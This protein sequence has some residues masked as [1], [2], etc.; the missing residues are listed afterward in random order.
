MKKIKDKDRS[1]YKRRDITKRVLSLFAAAVISAGPV[2]TFVGCSGIKDLLNPTNAKITTVDFSNLPGDP[3]VDIDNEEDPAL[4][5][6]ELMVINTVGEKDAYGDRV[7]WIE[8]F[9]QSTETVMLSDYEISLN[10]EL[11]VSLPQMT[12]TPGEY[13]V[14]YANGKSGG[15]DIS[16]TLPVKGLL[17]LRHN[18]FAT[19]KVSYLNPNANCSYLPQTGTETSQPTPGY[20]AVKEKDSIVISE[21]MSTNDLYPVD[22]KL[23]DWV[24]IFN[25]GENAVDLSKYYASNVPSD[26]YRC[27][28]PSVTLTP[29]EYL[30]LSCGGDLNFN[31]SKSGDKV[32]ITR[33]D[34]VIAS[35][36]TFDAMEKNTAWTYDRGIITKPSPGY[37]NTDDGCLAAISSHV[38]LIITEVISSNSKYNA[39]DGE[40]HD[41]VELKNATDSPIKLSD[42]CLSDKSSNLSRYILPDVTLAAGEYY[43]VACDGKKY[44]PFKISSKGEKLYV[45]KIDGTVI[46]ALEIPAVPANRS[47]GRSSDGTLVYFADPTFGKANGVGYTTIVSA[48]KASLQSGFYSGV[49]NVTLS[50]EGT[51]YYTT[52]GSKPT[53][54]SKVYDGKPIAVSGVMSIRVVAYDGDR[55][56]SDVTTFNYFIDIPDYSNPV[57]KISMAQADFDGTNGIYTKYNNTD[58]EKEA[59]FAYYVGG[60]EQFSVNCGIKIFGAS[61]RMYA[62]KSFQLKFRTKY[63]LSKLDYKFFDD[64]DI[65]EFNNIVMR[66]GSQ[67]IM[68][69]RTMLTDE[70]ITSIAS[71]SGNMKNVLVQ[72]Y[73]PINLYINDRYMGVYFFR[74]KIDEDF[75]ANHWGVDPD[76]VTIINW[77]NSVKYGTSDQGWHDLWDFVANKK[78]DLTKDENYQKVISQINVES[79]MDVY[80]MRIWGGDR[81]S[82]NIRA[83][84]SPDYDNGRW[85]FL[86]FDC[87]LCLD[88][89]STKDELDYIMNN[90]SIARLHTLFRSLMK[91]ENFKKEFLTRLGYHLK[92]TFTPEKTQGRFD[93]LVAEVDPDMKYNVECWKDTYHKTYSD[94][95]AN[96]NALR[97]SIGETRISLFVRDAVK[98]FSLTEDDVRTYFGE[99]FVAYMN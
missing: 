55:I 10:D 61:S 50:G 32:F 89:G 75:V 35:S 27:Q 1:K 12:L 91:N 57:V 26:L 88:V 13:V 65:T 43:V 48:P 81:D 31:L 25:A 79:F 19:A 33:S 28:L 83:A 22:G 20:A 52:D 95:K 70:L 46:D 41:L 86:L 17:I 97:K 42:Y 92:N 82:G 6:T 64:L 80:I 14:L 72:A 8:I 67:S 37:P 59:G 3:T 29:G 93:A 24:E 21:L 49:Q 11:P 7:G 84:K 62:K 98:T 69:Y 58:L 15:R 44:A 36:C 34:G 63:G 87:D 68:K 60:V 56:P 99:E 77:V 45:S 76:S 85:N 51:L 23:C 30:V 40:Y 4:V 5:I 18:E 71:T 90:S 73:K 66:S 74:E 47:F 54:N 38:G 53:K 39:I 2:C 9:N 16:L 78:S 96:V 94:W